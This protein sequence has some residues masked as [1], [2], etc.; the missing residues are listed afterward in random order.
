MQEAGGVTPSPY[1]PSQAMGRLNKQLCNSNISLCQQARNHSPICLLLADVHGILAVSNS[2]YRA[3]GGCFDLPQRERAVLAHESLDGLVLP[4]I[5]APK[6]SEHLRSPESKLPP[7]L[8]VTSRISQERKCPNDRCL[9]R[10]TATAQSKIAPTTHS[11]VPPCY[12][13]PYAAR[14][15]RPAG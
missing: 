3:L 6:E 9:A 4:G 7:T 2:P 13:P 8:G 15:A 10:S 14:D 12:T 1:S 11:S 5:L